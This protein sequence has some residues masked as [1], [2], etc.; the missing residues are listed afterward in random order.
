[1]SVL[2]S[3]QWRYAT[4]AMNGEMLDEATL[5]YILNAIRLTASSYGLQPYTVQVINSAELKAKLAPAAYNQPQINQSS[6]VLV[7]S[8]WNDI[9]EAHVDDYMNDIALERGIPVESL[10]GF[11]AMIMGAI[12]NLT[13][14]QK[15]AWAA[16]QAYIALGTALIAAAEQKVDATPMEG[17]NPQQVDAILGLE[18]LGLKSTVLLVLGK[19]SADDALASL[20]KV[21]RSQE[22]MFNFFN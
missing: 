12:I 5:T 20:A 16:K 8:I 14:E 21:R 9:T 17:F 2:D 19:R 15:Q 13:I 1:M 7:F 22:R 10:G 18:Q 6:Q 11:K 3:L 4:K